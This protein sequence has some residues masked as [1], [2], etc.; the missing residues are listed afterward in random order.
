MSYYDYYYQYN[1]LKSVIDK[2]GL[3]RFTFVKKFNKHTSQGSVGVL[4]YV[5]DLSNGSTHEE[6]EARD[7]ILTISK[8]DDKYIIYKIGLETPYLSTHEYIVA[9]SLYVG[10]SKFLPTFVR[11]YGLISN[12]KT[13][14]SKPNPFKEKN[15]VN[16]VM[17]FEHIQTCTSLANIIEKKLLPFKMVNSLLN[18]LM[19]SILVAQHKVD[20]VHNDLHFD[21]VLVSKCLKRTFM[22]YIFQTKG[23]DEVKFALIP[24]YGYFP[25]IIDYGFSYTKDLLDRNLYIGIHHNNK[26][27][28][29]YCYDEFTDFKGILTRLYYSR[30][31]FKDDKNLSFN[32]FKTKVNATLFKLPIDKQ[33]GWDN[34]KEKSISKQLIYYI[35]PYIYGS[36]FIEENEAIFVDIICTLIILPLEE[37]AYK[38]VDSYIKTFL[39]EWYKIERWFF[40][41]E[42]KIYILKNIVSFISKE[43]SADTKVDYVHAFKANLNDLIDNYG[44]K[45]LLQDINFKNLYDSI[46][47][48]S[49]CFEGIMFKLSQRCVKRK[50]KE[51][52]L[53]DG[54]HT[55]FD[56][57]KIV[58]PYVTD[59]S[60]ELMLNDYVIVFDCINEA[61]YSFVMKDELI[62]QEYKDIEK[63]EDKIRFLLTLTNTLDDCS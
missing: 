5:K 16:D 37:K 10:T 41:K 22:L 12:V 50:A 32:A 51:W 11:P 36:S 29:T 60:E 45:I 28:M 23:S 54:I 24:S 26:G 39:E 7:F 55:S 49:I 48:M 40:V 13:N 58:E 30:Y 27:Y 25:T 47:G 44:Y 18:Q 53:M 52:A 34:V 33:T 1:F 14:P 19:V 56:M 9:T 43:M 21:N 46:V 38:G 59:T 17:L 62:V 6:A 35:R 61:S 3:G 42:E 57:Y 8:R 2:Y 4:E 63:Y 15:F 31:K 20:F